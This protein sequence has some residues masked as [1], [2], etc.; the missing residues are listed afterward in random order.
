MSSQTEQVAE[1]FKRSA[2]YLLPSFELVSSS[3]GSRVH[4]DD[5]PATPRFTENDPL[6]EL[7]ARGCTVF[8]AGK[9]IYEAESPD[10]AAI[11]VD[12]HISV[13]A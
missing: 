12:R 3:A 2:L 6:P 11:Y 10:A 4:E 5:A 8:Y 7:S 1:L 13:Y 9:P